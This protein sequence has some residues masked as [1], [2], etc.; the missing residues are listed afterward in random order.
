[1]MLCVCNYSIK[2]YIQR[3]HQIIV[4][5]IIQSTTFQEHI[6]SG[7]VGGTCDVSKYSYDYFL[8]SAGSSGLL[9]CY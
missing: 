3:S 2:R 6:W 4:K 5:C 9:F 1:M 7:E 8:F